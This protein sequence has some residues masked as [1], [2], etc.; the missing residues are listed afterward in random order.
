MH[1]RCVYVCIYIKRVYIYRKIIPK[2]NDHLC[3]AKLKKTRRF[4]LMKIFGSK[5]LGPP[6]RLKFWLRKS[7]ILG[8]ITNHRVK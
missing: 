6:S 8:I 1:C 4:E 5:S 2:I 7:L 3:S